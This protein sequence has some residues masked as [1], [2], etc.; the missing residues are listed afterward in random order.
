MGFK[1][2]SFETWANEMS[3]Y[4]GSCLSSYNSDYEERSINL[5]RRYDEKEDISI[6]KNE[7]LDIIDS[8]LS[9]PYEEDM[10]IIQD[11]KHD[12]DDIY[13]LGFIDI[14]LNPETSEDEFKS[15]LKYI[16]SNY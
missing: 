5:Y 11:I 10:K 3:K 16:N 7:M 9:S 14:I 8:I 13:N 12:I 4:K 1:N 6:I 2:I 15:F